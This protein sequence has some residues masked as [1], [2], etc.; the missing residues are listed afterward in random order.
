[1]KKTISV[2][3]ALFLAFSCASFAFAA[4]SED[5]F[6]AYDHVFI[7]GVDGAGRFFKDANTP[8]FDRIFK[9]GAVDYTARA[10]TITI[11]AQNWGSILTGVSYL[12]HRMTNSVTESTPRTSD[13]KYPTIFTLLHKADPAAKLA[14]YTNWGAITKGIVENDLGADEVQIGDDGQLTDAMCEYFDAGNKPKLFFSQLDSV[15]H[16]GHEYGSK[17]PEYFAQI[18]DSLTRNGL[19]ENGLFIVVADHGHRVSKG[20]GG[21]TMRETNV[22]VAVAGKT[23]AAGGTMDK[24]TRNRDVAAIALYA[25]G[26]ERPDHM[27]ARI[28]ANL[29]TGVGGERRS[30]RNDFA[31]AV[32]SRIVW[33][34]TLCTAWI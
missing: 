17:A 20:H 34:I 11:S 9:D 29:F 8:N 25:L 14:V 2:L 26:V 15:D 28:P 24:D 10:E 13:T 12:R 4:Q 31:D 3:L 1:M 18:Y 30:V 21:L 22:M 5:S 16:F 32:F 7:I 23:V 33:P 19:M 27:S 6:G